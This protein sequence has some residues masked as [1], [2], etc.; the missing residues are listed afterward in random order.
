MPP[1]CASGRRLPPP[2]RFDACLPLAFDP[3]LPQPALLDSW[4]HTAASTSPCPLHGLPTARPSPLVPD[5]HAT[6]CTA[7]AAEP[8]PL[9][10]PV[11]LPECALTA[12]STSPPPSTLWAPLYSILCPDRVDACLPAC[13]QHSPLAPTWP[14][15]PHAVQT[16]DGCV[17]S[18]SRQP[19]AIE[20]NRGIGG[21][22]SGAHAQ[23]GGGRRTSCRPPPQA[24]AGPPARPPAAHGVRP[25]PPRCRGVAR[26]QPT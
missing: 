18:K 25:R 12:C 15:L 24:A 22:L 10:S 3:P 13:S 16:T 1:A 23:E 4:P 11:P 7:L 19:T 9:S 2:L 14:C 17:I 6:H 5:T 26:P 20:R 21:R 8:P